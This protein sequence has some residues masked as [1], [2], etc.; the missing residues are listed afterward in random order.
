MVISNTDTIFLQ[1]N[2]RSIQ[3]NLSYLF[4]HLESNEY[5]AII[6]QSLNVNTNKL[7]KLDN[8][9]YPP[10][11]HCDS[12]NGKINCAIYIKTGLDYSFLPSPIPKDTPDIHSTGV[13]VKICDSLTLNIVSTY[14]PRGPN[15]KNTE[16]LRSLQI[17]KEKWLIAG[18]F[19]AHSAFWEQNCY[20]T[21]D[22][23]KTLLIAL[24]TY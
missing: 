9:Y 11:Y 3:T 22:L 23:L 8:Y 21:I 19:N 6:L 5:Q 1:W 18:D 2:C 24:F 13:T 15:D 14:L 16:W 4:Q 17:Q 7:P 10:V 20:K 12:E